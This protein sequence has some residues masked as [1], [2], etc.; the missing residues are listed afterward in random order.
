MEKIIMSNRV[1]VLSSAPWVRKIFC[2]S[3]EALEQSNVSS[4]EYFEGNYE[5]KYQELLQPEMKWSITKA[6]HLLAREDPEDSH[7]RNYPKSQDYEKFFKAMELDYQVGKLLLIKQ[8]GFDGKT[9][10]VVENIVII[11]WAIDRGF[12]ARLPEVFIEFSGEYPT[13]G[14]AL[15][16][17]NNR[18]ESDL[19]DNVNIFRQKGKVYEIKYE[20]FEPFYL[21]VS[22]KLKR[23]EFLIKRSHQNIPVNT[24]FYSCSPVIG[25]DSIMVDEDE[26]DGFRQGDDTADP[27]PVCDLEA[28]AKIESDLDERIME[29]ELVG[30]LKLEENLKDKKEKV[31][32]FRKKNSFQDKSNIFP[33]DTGRRGDT[34]QKTIKEGVKEI[35]EICPALGAHLKEFITTR[36]L[37][38]YKPTQET[39]WL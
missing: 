34:I 7:W 20:E 25:E 14:K 39:K 5:K 30:N 36:S 15:P 21:P 13:N 33:T 10:L 17:I 28:L 37:C 23:I 4:K 19:L 16:L 8:H 35:N 3:K 11:R 12:G 26:L 29:A 18:E 2:I 24:L 1:F 27:D 22:I 6:A 38:S 32:Q 9:E 31:I